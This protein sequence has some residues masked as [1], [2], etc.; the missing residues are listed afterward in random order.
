MHSFEVVFK[1]GSALRNDIRHGRTGG[2]VNQGSTYMSER[3]V[4]SGDFEL[5]NSLGDRD[6]LYLHIQGWLAVLKG[7]EQIKCLLYNL[8]DIVSCEGTNYN[9]T[10]IRNYP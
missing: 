4:G 6:K 1:E 2:N 7:G 5:S 9:M 3:K 8:C 10:I